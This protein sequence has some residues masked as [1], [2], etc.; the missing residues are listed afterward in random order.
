MNNKK[1]R[2]I[3]L[4]VIMLLSLLTYVPFKVEA[5]GTTLPKPSYPAGS[6]AALHGALKI[7]GKNIYDASG[8]KFQMRGV[9]THGLQWDGDPYGDVGGTYVSEASFKT[10]RDDWGA[11]AIRLALYVDQGGYADSSKRT[12]LKNKVMNG[13]KYATNLGMYVVIDW[14]I[15]DSDPNNHKTEAIEFFKEM[16]ATYKNY[17]NVIFE[18]CNE[19]S[20]IQW[21][22]IKRYATDVIREIRKISNHIVIV[23]TPRYSQLTLNAWEAN[24]NDV[25]DDPITGYSNIAYSLHFYCNESGHTRDLPGKLQ[26]ALNK[27]IPVVISEFGLSAANGNDGINKSQADKWMSILNSDGNKISYFCWSLSRK[28]ESSA[29]LKSS[30]SSTSNWSDSELSDAGKYIKDLYKKEAKKDSVFS[31]PGWHQSNGSWYYVYNGKLKTGWLLDNGKWYYFDG[32]GKM[33]LGWKLINGKWYYFV[34]GGAMATG[35]TK[36][37]DVYYYFYSDGH[38]ASNEWING[39][40]LGENGSWTYKAKGSWRKNAKGSWFGDTSGWYAK[41]MSLK[42]DGK[43]YKFDSLGYLIQ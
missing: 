32:S 17:D 34:P 22:T 33:Q 40:W 30:T 12:Q 10:L 37:K 23:G 27:N 4:T 6:P 35:W 43:E 18:I 21:S 38:M 16:A 25:A 11:N 41:N 39:Y 31:T 19:P 15:L 14:H 5:A 29:L 3:I 1:I 36:V 8:N 24:S 7:S 9:S 2:S 42:I 20:A 28:N 26:Y 13:V